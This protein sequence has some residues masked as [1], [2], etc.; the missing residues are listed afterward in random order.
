MLFVVAMNKIL[1]KWLSCQSFET[2]GLFV[3]VTIMCSGYNCFAINSILK[4]YVTMHGLGLFK[5]KMVKYIIS[6]ELLPLKY[7]LIHAVSFKLNI[8]LWLKNCEWWWNQLNRDSWTYPWK[9][10]A[11]LFAINMLHIS[12][13]YRQVSNISRSLV[14]NKIVDHSDV[15]GASPVGAAPTTSSFS[16]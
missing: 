16:T 13:I 4:I 11:Q 5:R 7:Y 9:C 6:R 8:S 12:Y 14:G 1:H 2:H 15:V 3:S 10:Y